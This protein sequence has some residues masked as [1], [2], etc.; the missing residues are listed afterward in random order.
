MGK[1]DSQDEKPLAR[2]SVFT[3]LLS[4]ARSFDQLFSRLC[5]TSNAGRV[6]L[7]LTIV[8]VGVKLFLAWKVGPTYDTDSFCM[9][10]DRVLDGFTPYAVGKRYNYGP[11]WGYFIAAMRAVFGRTLPFSVVIPLILADMSIAWLLF[12]KGW[13][14]AAILFL[15]SPFGLVVT[16]YMRMFD[17]VAIAIALWG[18]LTWG[19]DDSSDKWRAVKLSLV[20]GFSIATKHILVFFPFWLFFRER[21]TAD[22]LTLLIL[23]LAL[24]GLSFT[25]PLAQE[26]FRGGIPAVE[27]FVGNFLTNV[28]GYNPWNQHD[29]SFWRDFMPRALLPIMPYEQLMI[30]AVL[31]TGWLFRRKTTF[32][33]FV[34]YL[35]SL[36]LFSPGHFVQYWMIPLVFVS[37]MG[38]WCAMAYGVVAV[39]GL[40][41]TMQAAGGF[42]WVICLSEGSSQVLLALLALALIR[43]Y[44]S[45]T[46][47][48]DRAA[49]ER[50]RC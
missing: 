8:G 27:Q 15:L 41:S 4:G 50:E 13:R 6:F 40:Y 10:G 5:A 24:F 25:I 21:R 2:E 1:L 49:L 19:E 12:R 30:V 44:C 46:C 33:A 11:V 29:V 34:A 3:R 45:T 36:V 28:S 37:V 39:W 38:F 23:P 26:M 17:G 47:C 35:A 48:P 16:G 14:A 20:L 18:V 42:C 31:V 7:L 43:F 22:R 32:G 9:V